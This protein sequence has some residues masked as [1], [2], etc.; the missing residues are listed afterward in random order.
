MNEYLPIAN[1]I[2][3]IAALP[4]NLSL[5]SAYNCPIFPIPTRDF[6]LLF[7]TITRD[8]FSHGAGLALTGVANLST[9]MLGIP[10]RQGLA[11][12]NAT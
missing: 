4:A 10:A 6:F 2:T 11:T 8:G 5:N 3:F 7:P 12:N 1:T 9:C